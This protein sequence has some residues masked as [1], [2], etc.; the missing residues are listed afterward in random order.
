MKLA[1]AYA[2]A[3]II[4]PEELHGDY[5]IPSVFDKRVAE[6]VS[7]DVEEAAYRTGVAGVTARAPTR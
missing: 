6:S 2:I 5:I 3:S 1:A 4:K 7:R